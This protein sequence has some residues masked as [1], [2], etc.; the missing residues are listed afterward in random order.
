MIKD[1]IGHKRQDLVTLQLAWFK[2]G[3][4]KDTELRIILN[5][6]EGKDI[7]VDI[8]AN[9]GT[10]SINYASANPNSIVYSIEPAIENIEILKRNILKHSITNIK[11][12]N[13]A[14]D[15]KITTGTLYVNERNS[16]DNRI[17]RTPD[18]GAMDSHE[19]E[20][21][22][23]NDFKK[24]NNIKK[25]DYIKMDTQGCE[26]DIMTGGYSTIIND[27][28]DIF[29]EF[30]PRG[31]QQ[32]GG[33]IEIFKKIVDKCEYNIYRLDERDNIIQVT[34][35][36][37]MDFYIEHLDIDFHINLFLLKGYL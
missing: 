22:T 11:I 12:I 35:G 32:K 8:G 26:L 28:P 34:L 5:L 19:I 3:R 18:W 4:I 20:I 33:D 6:I 37:V 29:M 9:L 7:I 36:A 30:W 27:R 17:Y 25:I 16:G 15:K 13:K 14:F 21:T 10:H 1:F 23:L 2:S 24:E 31:F